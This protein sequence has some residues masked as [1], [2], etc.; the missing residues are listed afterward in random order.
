ML[1][2]LLYSACITFGTASVVL[3][4]YPFFDES[5]SIMRFLPAAIAC[6]ASAFASLH[7]KWQIE[8]MEETERLDRAANRAQLEPAQQVNVEPQRQNT[9]NDARMTGRV[10]VNFATRVV[11][12]F[13]RE[14]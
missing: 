11:N 12:H 4:F 7:G 14:R 8:E 5:V 13:A 1:K 3:I 2:K 9:T 10:V 6:G